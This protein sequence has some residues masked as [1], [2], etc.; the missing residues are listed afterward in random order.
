MATTARNV[1]AGA[2]VASPRWAHLGAIAVALGAAIALMITVFVARAELHDASYVLVRGEGQTLVSLIH[3]SLEQR[4]DS[5][6]PQ[7]EE[8]E[9]ELLRFWPSGLRSL[10]IVEP[11]SL[12][13]VGEPRFSMTDVAPGH[14]LVQSGRARLAV[15]LP[16]PRRRPPPR[17][18]PRNRPLLVIEFEP[19]V[20]GR[21]EGGIGRSGLVGV[22]AAFVLVAFASVLTLRLARRAGV[23]RQ[24]ERERRLASLGQ[25]SGVMAHE[26]RNPLASLKGHAQ[27]L[28]EMLSPMSPEHTKA[29]LV[30][31]EAG[32]LERLT[33]DLLAFVRDGDL[34]RASIEPRALLEQAL[35]G[36]PRGRISVDLSAAPPSLWVDQVRLGAALNNLVRNALQASTGM[37][38]IEMWGSAR[39]GGEVCIEVRDDGPGLPPGEEERVFEPFVTTRVQGTGLGLTVARRAVEQHGGALTGSTHPAGGAVFR[40]V[41]PTLDR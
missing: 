11:E 17:D 24:I 9:A 15:P 7:R 12:L 16:P 14:T 31:S 38:R 39:V 22:L 28:A 2:W 19:A 10:A 5:G 8:L 13:M 30:V 20:L 6:P 21:L 32:R 3:Q 36:H 33:Q 25:M 35:V 40:V 37:V 23:E 41:L 4:S 34:V 26:L 1:G 29:Q 27:L 18:P